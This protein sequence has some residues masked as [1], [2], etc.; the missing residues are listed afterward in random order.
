MNLTRRDASWAIKALRNDTLPLFAD[1]DRREH[2]FK[3]EFT[4]ATVALPAMTKGREVVEDYR[5]HGL[6]LRSHP[7]AFLRV[8]LT[9]AGIMPCASLQDA[10]DGQ[11]VTVA[12]LVLVRQRPGSAKGVM[13]I[14]LED[15]SDIA[16][17]IVWPSLFEKQRPIVIGAQMIAC[18][19]RVQKATG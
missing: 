2:Q 5:S 17:L 10:P 14:T 8:D 13:F 12:G 4:E 18:R 1:A 15:E 19:G 9:A 3:L 6:T 11:R 16:N 7:L